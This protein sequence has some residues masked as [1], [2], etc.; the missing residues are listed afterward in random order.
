MSKPLRGIIGKQGPKEYGRGDHRCTPPVIWKAALYAIGADQF[1]LDPA[2]NAHSTVPASLCFDGSSIE[3]DGLV[4]GW[5]GNVWLNFPFSDPM[6]WVEKVLREAHRCRSI[7]VLGPNDTSTQWHRLLVRC[8]DATAQWPRRVH[9]PLPDTKRG[10][11]PG[12]IALFYIGPQ[13]NAWMRV[14]RDAYKCQVY[15]GSLQGER[16]I[17][18]RSKKRPR[19]L[20]DL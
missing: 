14:M 11:P 7:T 19:R 4:Q 6:P 13:S 10:S 3:L 5:E 20:E 2:T 16:P 18:L 15:P 12:P 1:D 9:F 8:V 17:I